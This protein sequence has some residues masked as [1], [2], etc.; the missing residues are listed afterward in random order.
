[1]C[2]LNLVTKRN[3]KILSF[4][5]IFI[6]S[7]ASQAATNNFSQKNFDETRYETLKISKF[8]T[9]GVDLQTEKVFRN[10]LSAELSNK[11]LVLEPKGKESTELTEKPDKILI[12]SLSRLGQK[13]VI[14]ILLKNADTLQ[15][16]YQERVNALSITELDIVAERLAK[17]LLDN[18][19]FEQSATYSNFILSYSLSYIKKKIRENP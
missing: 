1:M 9:L 8:E 13:I 11:Y 14:V 10:I 3:F 12:G 2:Q 16:E 4:I 18:K 5:Y 15:V 6:L 7:L 17:S 19:T